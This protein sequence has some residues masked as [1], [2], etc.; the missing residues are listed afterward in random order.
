[1]ILQCQPFA[2]HFMHSYLLVEFL[3]PDNINKS[4]KPIIKA[5]IKLLRTKQVLDKLTTSD[6]PQPRRSLLPLPWRCSAL[7]N[8][9]GDTNDTMEIKW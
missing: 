1:M 3:N 8:G 7:A 2:S 4:Y 5:V 9:D 6:N